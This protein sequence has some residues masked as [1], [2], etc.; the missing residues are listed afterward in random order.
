MCLCLR[1]GCVGAWVGVHDVGRGQ[2]GR[3]SAGADWA[4]H[5]TLLHAR[6][7]AVRER[8]LQRGACGTGGAVVAAARGETGL[9]VRRALLRASAQLMARQRRPLNVARHYTR[10]TRVTP[11]FRLRVMRVRW[12]ETA[13]TCDTLRSHRSRAAASRARARP[14]CSST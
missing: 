9:V 13:Q 3:H 2:A 10:G 4:G 12:R 7:T 14:S 1:V 11:R 6:C 5:T 8:Y